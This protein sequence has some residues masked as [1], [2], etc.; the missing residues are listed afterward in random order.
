[1]KKYFVKE[2]KKWIKK[3]YFK[4]KFYLCSRDI[5]VGEEFLQKGIFAIHPTARFV[6]TEV[7]EEWI[8]DDEN[9]KYAPAT[10]YKIIGE[11]SPD[12]TWVKEGD[13]FDEDQILKWDIIGS[14]YKFIQ[15]KGACNH[16]H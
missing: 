4:S 3:G 1:M 7:T 12:V 10:V 16:F 11:I 9:K 8:K 15:I 2:E 14:E 13:E 6:A 5:Q